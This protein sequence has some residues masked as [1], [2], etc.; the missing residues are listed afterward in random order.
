MAAAVAGQL[1][2]VCRTFQIKKTSPALATSSL[3]PFVGAHSTSFTPASK[4]SVF[5][6][7]HQT[8]RPASRNVRV[9]RSSVAEVEA[10]PAPAAVGNVMLEVKGLTAKIA[11]SG[12]EILKGVDLVIREGE[13]SFPLHNL[14][15]YGDDEV[16]LRLPHAPILIRANI[17]D[18]SPIQS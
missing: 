15:L 7:E 10:P 2:G 1:G 8:R 18:L 4:N 12:K 5:Y 13:V 17:Y 14:S 3:K 16:Q 11:D 6:R 9:T